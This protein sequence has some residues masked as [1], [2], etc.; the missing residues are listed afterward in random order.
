MGNRRKH[1]RVSYHEKYKLDFV[2]NDNSFGTI[3]L[4]EKG[5]RYNNS[6]DGVVEIGN[7]VK[8]KITL[9][10]SSTN[11]GLSGTV[12]RMTNNEIAVI[13]NHELQL[14]RIALLKEYHNSLKARSN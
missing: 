14:P 3:D 11:Y 2:V 9:K 8:G 7:P 10:S 6:I 12:A 5:I 1:L 4:S 13:F